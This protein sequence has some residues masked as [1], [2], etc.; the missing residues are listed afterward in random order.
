MFADVT[1]QQEVR[2]T[3]GEMF[4]RERI[5]ILV[6]NAGVSHIGPWRILLKLI[7][8]VCFAST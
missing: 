8:I 6:N 3:F 5:H 1:S 7:W 2:A 4:Q